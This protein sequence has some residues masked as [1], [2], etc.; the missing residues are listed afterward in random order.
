MSTPFSDIYA[1]TKADMTGIVMQCHLPQNHAM[2]NSS[3]L[4]MVLGK[5]EIGVK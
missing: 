1:K 5:Y 3:I 2:Y 4:E